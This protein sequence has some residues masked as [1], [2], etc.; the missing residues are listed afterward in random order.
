MMEEHGI[1]LS[2]TLTNHFF[3]EAVYRQ[4]CDLLQRHHELGNSIICVSDKLARRLRQD[5]P[6]YILKASVIKNLNTLD[7]I[8]AALTLYD[9]VTVPMD[10]NDD[11]AF[12]EQL[13]EKRRIIL[14]GNATC[15]YTCPSRTCYLG[16]SQEIQGK[17]VTSKCSREMIPR[18][19]LGLVHFDVNKLREMGFTHFKLVPKESKQLETIARLYSNKGNG[20]R[21]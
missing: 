5:F 17:P 14:F 19:T 16:F 20:Y 21:D 9:Y 2:L 18:P 13:P 11:D 15:A 7:K 6:N 12:L 3:D 4:S 8:R 10:K 1:C